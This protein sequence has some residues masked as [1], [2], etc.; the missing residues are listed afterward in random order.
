MTRI[1]VSVFTNILY[2]NGTLELAE[3]S[4]CIVLFTLLIVFCLNRRNSWRN[5]RTCW[6]RG[7]HTGLLRAV[8][9]CTYTPNVVNTA[10]TTKIRHARLTRRAWP[11]TMESTQ[12]WLPIKEVQRGSNFN[13]KSIRVEESSQT[14]QWVDI[15]RS[16]ETQDIG[17]YELI[18]SG[19]TGGK[20]SITL[21]RFS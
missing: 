19:C 17:A 12:G 3:C 9:S 20:S 5:P 16:C 18:T 6:Q 10:T 15:Y 7:S 14:N 4:N 21:I 11:G 1:S 8:L 2:G 13:Y